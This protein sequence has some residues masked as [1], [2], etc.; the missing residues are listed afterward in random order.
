VRHLAS[1]RVRGA[2]QAIS[3]R[4]AFSPLVIAAFVYVPLVVLYAATDPSIFEIEFES[5]KAFSWSGLTY[6]ALAL[7]LFAAGAKAADDATRS[8]RLRRSEKGSRIDLSPAQRRSL[9]VIVELALVV[10][11]AAYVVWLGTGVLRAGGVL[12]L[13]ELWRV[14]PE[15]VKAETLATIPG[16]TTLTQLA[17]A[18][19]PLALAFRIARRGTLVLPLIAVVLVLAVARTV[20]YSERL[21]LIE[22]VVPILFVL[23]A[24]RKVHVPR[25]V[26]YALVLLIAAVTFF[27]ATELR[28]SYAYTGDF[29]ASSATTRLFGYYVTSINNGMAFL[30]E[31]PA[32][33]PAYTTAEILWTFP[34]VGD[35]HVDHLP[36]VG[37]LS[38]RY[39]DLFGSDPDRF[40]APAFAAQD[41][42][43]EFNVLTTPGYLAVDFGWAGLVGMLVLGLVS[44]WI[45]RRSETSPFHLALYAVW[46]VGLLELMRILY[47]TDSRLFPAYLVFLAAYLVVRQ[48]PGR[49]HAHPRAREVPSPGGTGR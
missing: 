21:A 13:I 14:D 24:P 6:F 8:S 28:R 33:T 36:A 44:G 47:F 41:L 42:D 38:L 30:D 20:L 45:Y 25:V 22:L 16:V 3:L 18:A 15:G 43:Y 19:I 1:T 39:A 31:Y 35:L 40:W 27:A 46:L 48:A 29:S 4:S 10:S 23:I 7:A 9:E 12:E 5:R 49:A 17:V 26:V 11:I 2:G 37:S 34:V 32:H